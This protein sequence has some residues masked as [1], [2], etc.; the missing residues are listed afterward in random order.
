MQYAA[1][2]KAKDGILD[3][4]PNPPQGR[5]LDCH[6]LLCLLM[7]ETLLQVLLSVMCF[8]GFAI[9]RKVL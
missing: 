5:E 7:Y 1:F 4:H 3:T 2:R 9:R 6:V 8:G